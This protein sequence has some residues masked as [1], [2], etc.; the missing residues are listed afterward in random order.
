VR[1]S[2]FALGAAGLL[3]AALAFAYAPVFANG[4]VWDDWTTVVATRPSRGLG[5]EGV[6]WAFTSFVM[7]HWQP[8]TSLSYAVDDRLWGGAPWGAHLGNLLLHALNALLVALLA[9]ELFRRSRGNGRRSEDLALGVL[10]ALAAALFALH[11][12]RVESVAWATERR[13]VLSAC[14]FLLC[15]LFYLKRFS[16]ARPRAARAWYAASLA[17][18]LLGLLAKAQVA[19]PGVL[20]VL[21]AWPLRR[22]ASRASARRALAEKLPYF[23][24]S[25]AAAAVALRAQAS[26]GALVSTAEHGPFARLA[27]AAYGLVFY[28]RA[29]FARAWYPLYERPVPLDPGEPRFLLSM[30]AAA[31]GIALL[32]ALRRRF[33]SVF[34]AAAAYLVLLA[35]VLG[36]AQSGVQLVADRYSYL[37][38][39]GW[40][41]ATA[42]GIGVWWRRARM[43]TSRAGR[44]AWAAL[45]LGVLAL[46]TG[47]TRAQT[48]VWRDDE[49]L[50]RHVLRGGPSALAENN[51]AHLLLQRGETA[52]A[53]EHLRRSL[54]V[55]PSY[56]RPWPTLKTLLATGAVEPA[57]ARELVPVLRRS[58]P[59]QERSAGAH[60]TLGLALARAGLDREALAELDRA[61]A[62]A[63]GDPE[64][65][66][67]RKVIEERLGLV[68]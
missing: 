44:A 13:D 28:L 23:A 24:L 41:I 53:V 11:P 63:P 29:T 46:W 60:L 43:S 16:A 59:Y 25:A 19:L 62:L 50:W 35:P 2:R 15:L 58:I 31:L 20:L 9:A 12:M 33:P 47:Q 54:A 52:P 45:V 38:N 40:A 68:R 22:F 27:Q 8:L 4:F 65:V 26:A 56:A 57:A 21:D 37:A 66:F 39:V 18:F 34:A 32:L 3:L 5:A 6:R 30:L 67:Q 36:T 14:C 42:A 10:A 1:R 7:G 49:T 61:L 64:M 55:V 51:L 48:R 17:A